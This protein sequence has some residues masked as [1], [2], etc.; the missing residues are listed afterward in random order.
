[1]GFRVP[2][3]ISGNC[4][5][6]GTGDNDP[7]DQDGHGTHV[8]G[9]IGAAG[10]NGVGISGV[11]WNVLIMPVR[12]LNQNGEGSDA[13]IAAGIAYAVKM[14]A[15]VIN[16]SF[17]GFGLSQTLMDAVSDANAK[18]VL[19]VASAGNDSNNNDLNPVYP[20]SYPF[21]NIIS[22]AA[23]DQNDLRVSFS[24]F[25]TRSVDVAA[26]GVYIISTVPTWWADF[27]GFGHLEQFD[28]TSMSAPHVSGLA[29]LLYSYYINF[30]SSQIR[31]M[32]L[33]CV[34]VLPSLDGWVATRG[35]INAFSSMSALWEPFDLKLKQ[36]GDVVELSWT[37]VATFEEYTIIERKTQGG[38][39][40]VLADIGAER[41]FLHRQKRN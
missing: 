8:S 32:I 23:T 38:T 10:N 21:D 26:P 19:F 2:V 22:V 34:D 3:K 31:N 12:V 7:M 17:G 36:N 27:Q 15:K 9:I 6:P 13:D 24:N 40:A 37:D 16:A 18:G 28:G 35:R 41:E 39:Y 20:A 33:N 25:G 14:G 4:P 11:M 5:V 1:M 30:N 29:G